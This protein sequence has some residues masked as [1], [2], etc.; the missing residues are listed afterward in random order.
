MPNVLAYANAAIS[1]LYILLIGAI[2]FAI[3]YVGKFA[4]TKYGDFLNLF[5]PAV[6]VTPKSVQDFI[7]QPSTQPG[8]YVPWTPE[9]EPDEE[10]PPAWLQKGVL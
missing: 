1:L 2:I 3:Y 4:Y 9:V 10:Y 6:V 7:D 5:G 8:G